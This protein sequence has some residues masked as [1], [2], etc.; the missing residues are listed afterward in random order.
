MTNYRFGCM[1]LSKRSYCDLQKEHGGKAYEDL[2]V[3]YE[4]VPEDDDD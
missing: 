3:R 2:E 4:D 1:L